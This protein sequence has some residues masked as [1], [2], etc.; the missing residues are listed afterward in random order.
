MMNACSG[1]PGFFSAKLVNVW[2]RFSVECPN[3][4]VTMAERR[5]FMA[6]V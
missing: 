5:G 2:S 4:T 1:M 3:A 6:S